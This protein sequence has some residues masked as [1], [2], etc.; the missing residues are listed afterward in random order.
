MANTWKANKMRLKDRQTV[1][2]LGVFL[3]CDCVCAIYALM[4]VNNVIS[5]TV[6]TRKQ[7]K[8]ITTH[9]Q[10]THTERPTDNILFPLYLIKRKILEI[11]VH[12][13]V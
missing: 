6:V 7:T 2:L 13:T 3:F 4:S 11:A 1:H 9:M 12:C 8:P 5:A 10:H